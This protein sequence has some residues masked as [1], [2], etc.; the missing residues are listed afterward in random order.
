M[1]IPI[2]LQSCMLLKKENDFSY[3][4]FLVNCLNLKSKWIFFAQKSLLVNI[5]CPI[6]KISYFLLKIII[7]RRETYVKILDSWT[8]LRLG[9]WKV[10]T[11]NA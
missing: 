4:L 8:V 7:R 9:L 10:R 6:D 1:S 5:H 3:Q 11:I 2:K